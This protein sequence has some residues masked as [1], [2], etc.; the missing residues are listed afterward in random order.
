MDYELRSHFKQ[1]DVAGKG[2]SMTTDTGEVRLGAR[3]GQRVDP[4]RAVIS[5][6]FVTP[7]FQHS[8][9]V[10]HIVE[11]D[12]AKRAKLFRALAEAGYHCEIYGTLAELIDFRPSS[13]VV[14]YNE[15]DAQI[16]VEAA[17][18]ILRTATVPLAMVGCSEEPTIEV[19]VSAMRAGALN[20]VALPFDPA[21]I[22]LVLDE[23]AMADAHHRE[24]VAARCQAEES[25]AVLSK[26][27]FEV[28]QAISQGCSNKEAGR[29]LGISPRT[30]EIHR[31]KMMAKLGVS[32]VAGA[33]RILLQA[34]Q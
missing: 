6:D 18:A 32:S 19:V 8:R 10:V 16:S 22:R 2:G 12:H 27:E 25:L 13:G 20:Y 15:T 28:L 1:S 9:L 26:R 17:I 5:R 7:S 30:V 4:V 34:S 29:Q 31:A 3:R 14:L 33:V 24:K 23:V 21:K 11:P